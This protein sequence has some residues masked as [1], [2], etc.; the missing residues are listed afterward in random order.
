MDT[1][2]VIK[3]NDNMILSP[4]RAHKMAIRSFRLFVVKEAPEHV[5]YINFATHD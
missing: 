4:S 2:C 1:W 5:F 3:W